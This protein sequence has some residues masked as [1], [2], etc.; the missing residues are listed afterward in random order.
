MRSCGR[1]FEFAKSELALSVAH[2]GR[3]PIRVYR[4]IGPADQS[5]YQWLDLVEIP[6][7]ADIG[8][9][10]HHGDDEEI[11]IILSGHGRMTLDGRE[12]DVSP[13]HVIVNRPGGSHGLHNTGESPLRLVVVDARAE[14]PRR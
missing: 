5:A 12:F 13:G 9:H 3:A 4:A 14:A 1:I 6:A 2:D 10:T 8:V 11:Y 7:G